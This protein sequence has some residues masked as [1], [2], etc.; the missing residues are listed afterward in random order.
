MLAACVQSNYDFAMAFI[1]F[2]LYVSEFIVP[3]PI[4]VKGF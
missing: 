2:D 1:L 4:I 3:P